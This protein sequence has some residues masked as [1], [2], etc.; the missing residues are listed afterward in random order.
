MAETGTIPLL[1]GD[2]KAVILRPLVKLASVITVVAVPAG[3]L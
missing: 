2:P 3:G 1:N